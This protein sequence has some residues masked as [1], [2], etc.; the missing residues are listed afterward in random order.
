MTV[1]VTCTFS[2]ITPF[3][4]AV[5]GNNIPVAASAAFP[6]RNGTITGI[7]VDPTRPDAEPDPHTNAIAHSDAG[8]H[9]DA[10]RDRRQRRRRPPRRRRRPPHRRP[11]MCTVPNLFDVNI[12][13]AANKWGVGG[14]GAGFTTP[15]IFSPLVGQGDSG[16]VSTQSDGCRDVTSLHRHGDD[17]HLVEELMAARL[18]TRRQTAAAVARAWSSS[19]SSSR[20]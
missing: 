7:P 5:L 18:F 20:S 17:R 11:P 14:G 8:A 6:I 1:K 15:L 9:A 13:A 2:L 19:P 3:L 10:H 12:N 16:K 4:G